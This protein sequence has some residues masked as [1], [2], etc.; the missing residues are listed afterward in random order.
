MDYD[1]Q[2]AEERAAEVERELDEVLAQ[3]Y[4]LLV[5]AGLEQESTLL[6]DADRLRIETV[7]QREARGNPWG[8]SIF[9]AV[10]EVETFLVPRFTPQV[11]EQIWQRLSYVLTRHGRS[12]VE[13]LDVQET[14]PQVG[15]DWRERA[16]R[17]LL[18]EKATNQARRERLDPQYPTYGGMTF[19]SKEEIEVY[20]ILEKLQASTKAEQA[21][22]LMPLPAAQ[23]RGRAPRT[24][25]LV[26]VGNGR[27]M[28]IEVDGPHHRRATRVADDQQ[29]DLDWRRCGVQ[30]YRIPVDHLSE[31][32][33][34]EALIRE[35]VRRALWPQR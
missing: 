14:L 29:R 27:A 4:H 3:T 1:E 22:A 15:P 10:L 26:V 9:G 30:C 18:A 16:N 23:H 5:R 35:E 24:P 28:V 33:Q 25:D 6:L 8:Y 2:E 17:D 34:L 13:Q 21:I 12:G 20:K 19:G 11:R 32:D 31:P 7:G